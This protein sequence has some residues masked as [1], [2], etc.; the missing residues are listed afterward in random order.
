[1]TIQ[2]MIDARIRIQGGYRIEFWDNDK[3]NILAEGSSLEDEVCDIDD[4][5]LE[6]EVKFIYTNV[7]PSYYPN[8]PSATLIIEVE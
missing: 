7:E 8:C 6:R 4:D 1:M 2:D 3:Q 5:I